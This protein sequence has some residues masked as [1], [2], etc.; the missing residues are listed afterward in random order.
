MCPRDSAA[1]SRHAPGERSECPEFPPLASSFPSTAD[2]EQ[3]VHTFRANLDASS[4]YSTSLA[5]FLSPD[6]TERARRFHFDRDRVRY[7]IARGLLRALIGRYLSCHPASISFRYDSFGKPHLAHPDAK[8]FFNLSHSG[9]IALY[10]FTSAG[11]LGIDIAW[12][13]ARVQGE[14]IARRFFTSDECSFIQQGSSE[15]SQERFFYL[16]SRK[17]AYIKAVSKG[18]SVPLNEFEVAASSFVGG[19][20]IH[21]FRPGPDFS[22]AVAIPPG[23]SHIRFFDADRIDLAPGLSRTKLRNRA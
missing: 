19:F 14:K 11:E 9:N 12:H 3:S 6:E 1:Q 23:L 20:Q 7:S 16:W 18:L 13:D 21:S 8:L 10:A 22:A 2:L 15:G 5:A 17:E 4:S